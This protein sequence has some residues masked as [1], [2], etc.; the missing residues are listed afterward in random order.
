MQVQ[1]LVRAIAGDGAADLDGGLL[2]NDPGTSASC[3]VASGVAALA[4]V[5]VCVKLFSKTTRK[6]LRPPTSRALAFAI[7]FMADAFRRCS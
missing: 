4:P 1:H 5:A 2:R 3:A 6:S 7:R